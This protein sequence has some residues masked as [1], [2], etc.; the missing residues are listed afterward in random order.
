VRPDAV[1]HDRLGSHDD[2]LAGVEGDGGHDGAVLQI[3]LVEV[4]L[5]SML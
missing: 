4:L 2:R 3:R 5:E 1:G